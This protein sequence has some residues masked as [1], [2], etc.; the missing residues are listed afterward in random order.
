MF[1]DLLKSKW[2]FEA[3]AGAFAE[4]AFDIDG[5]VVELGDVFDDAEAEAGAADGA[6]AGFVDPVE[7][8]EEAGV[9]LRGDAGA[10][11]LDFD[12]GV[13]ALLVGFEGDGGF[14]VGVFDR[15][16]DEIEDGLLEERRVQ[17]SGEAVFG[18]DFEGQVPSLGGVFG[19][20]DGVF[21]EGAHFATAD[22]FGSVGT[23]DAGEGEEVVDDVDHAFGLHEDAVAVFLHGFPVVGFFG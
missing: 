11:V 4:F 7:A 13:V 10:V 12:H 18:F 8:F 1:P 5:A 20:G 2:D 23:F 22:A 14:G 19:E 6:A 21:E 17:H 3:E 15:I 16:L 9:V